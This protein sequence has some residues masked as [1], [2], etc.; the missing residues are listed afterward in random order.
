MK[1]I[2]TKV[3]IYIIAVVMAF[4]IKTSQDRQQAKAYSYE[5]ATKEEQQ[6]MKWQYELYGKE[7]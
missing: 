2:S 1:K 3:F 7:D 5:P 6:I 4:V